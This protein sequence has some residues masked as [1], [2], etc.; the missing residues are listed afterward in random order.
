MSERPEPKYFSTQVSE[1][2]RFYLELH[3]AAKRQLRVVCGGWER[4]RPDYDLERPGFPHLSIEVVCG[5]MGT[6]TLAGREYA[7]TP[8]T[9]FVYGPGVAHRIRA[10]RKHGLAKYFVAATGEEA[11]ELFEECHLAPAGVVRVRHPAELLR[12]CDDLIAR[13]LGDHANRRRMCGVALQ[14]LLMKIGDLSVPEDAPATA[15]LATYRRCRAF[16]EENFLSLHSLRETAAACHVDSAYLCRLFRRFRRQP[17]FQYLQSLKMNRAVDLLQDGRLNI[18]Q[19]AQELGFSDPYNFSRAFKR[20]FGI[21]PGRFL[22]GSGQGGSRAGERRA[23]DF[24][25]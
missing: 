20:V 3:P 14:Y 12:V 19:T 11:R 23:A 2:R 10:S 25:A 13:G 5:G 24:S 1:A 4:C 17:P 22:E 9:V 8:G 21:S 6:L 18:K 16:I 15:A 7:L